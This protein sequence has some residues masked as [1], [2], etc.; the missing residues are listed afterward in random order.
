M[1]DNGVEFITTGNEPFP[2]IV[3]TLDELILITHG[4]FIFDEFLPGNH[5]YGADICMQAKLKGR[6][7]YVIDAYL[8]H[9]SLRFGKLD[10]D[11]WQTRK[12]F[13]N[14]YSSYLPIGTTCTVISHN[15]E[16]TL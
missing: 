12:Y 6:H 2:H 9:N 13:K 3:D 4:D 14:K 10:I 1:Q 16:L 15:E 8:H 11:F 7:C 5:F